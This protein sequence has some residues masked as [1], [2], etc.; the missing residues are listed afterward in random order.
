DSPV[1]H[2]V[3]E[4]GVLDYAEGLLIGYRGFDTAG[5]A[6][7]YP[8]G[9]GLGY[10]AWSYESLH[11]ATA[12]LAPGADLELR[13]TV[14]NEGSRPGQEIVQAYVAGPPGDAARPVRVLG[15]FAVA[16]AGPGE[17]AEVTLRVPARVFARYDEEAGGWVWPHGRFT[18]EVGRSS[19]D[20][21]LS[22]PIVS[23]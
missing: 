6:P 8:F 17:T 20:L 11:L 4:D 15:A 7:H 14:R 19:R 22:A 16:V 23:A 5:L 13:V 21:R 1:L 9:H 12:N 3:P 2:A 10:T 18:V